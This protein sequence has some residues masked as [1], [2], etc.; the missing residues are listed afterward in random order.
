V[1]VEQVVVNGDNQGPTSGRLEARSLTPAEVTE[2]ES[3]GKAIP[4]P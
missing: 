2:I 3:H 1:G 4:K